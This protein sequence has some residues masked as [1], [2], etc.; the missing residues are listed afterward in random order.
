MAWNNS[1]RVCLFCQKLENFLSG[2][3]PD[4]LVAKDQRRM[5][6]IRKMV[7]SEIWMTPR[8]CSCSCWTLSRV[9]HQ[10]HSK[11]LFGCISTTIPVST[12]SSWDVKH[13]V[14][15]AFFKRKPAMRQQHSKRTKPVQLRGAMTTRHQAAQRPR[16]GE[17]SWYMWQ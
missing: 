5:Q 11:P 6:F 13:M 1:V 16:F 2:V 14:I 10:R 4:P 15:G 3:I 12:V 7:S 8:L 17:R 9:Q